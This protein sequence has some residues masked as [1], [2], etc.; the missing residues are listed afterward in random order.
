M[1][2]SQESLLH[3]GIFN[4]FA[5]MGHEWGLIPCEST[6]PENTQSTRL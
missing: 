2:D 4:N 5:T 1:E 6:T 3:F